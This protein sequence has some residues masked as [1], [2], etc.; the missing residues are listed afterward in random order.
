MSPDRLAQA[1]TGAL[2]MREV[3]IVTG[4]SRG[5]GAA[6]VRLLGARGADVIVNYRTE[7]AAADA[8]VG[9]IKAA[10]GRALAVA[11]D[12]GVEADV[13]RLFAETDRAVGALTG[14]V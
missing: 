7:Q 14:L 5:I 9:D 13:L 12:V 6:T 3:V 11:A 1:R 4:A 10:G 2:K 8:V